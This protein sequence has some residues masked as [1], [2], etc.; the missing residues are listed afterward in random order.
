MI[1]WRLLAL[2]LLAGILGVGTILVLRSSDDG[3][4]SPEEPPPAYDSWRWSD[5]PMPG[6]PPNV[7]LIS[8]D[9]LRADHLGCYGYSRETS[10]NIDSLARQG[11]VFEW[12]ISSSSW[13]LPTHL[14]MLTS[15]HW[16]VWSAE[17]DTN[18]TAVRQPRL[19]GVLRDHGYKTAGFYAGPLVSPTYG[20]DKGFDDYIDCQTTPWNALK[21]ITSPGIHDRVTR[22]LDEERGEP[23][24]LFIHYWDPHGLYIPPAPYDRI[25]DPDYEGKYVYPREPK[26]STADISPRDMKHLIALYD[27]EIRWTDKWIGELVRLLDA[28][29]FLD[30]T[31]IILTADH[32]EQLGE[33]GKIGHGLN[34]FDELIRVPLILRLPGKVPAGVR[35]RE[36]VSLIDIFPTILDVVGVERPPK[37]MGR[38]LA[39]LYQGKP[40]GGNPPPA[41]SSLFEQ[42]FALR[43]AGWKVVRGIDVQGA[44]FYDLVADPLERSPLPATED[45]RGRE[46]L[47]KLQQYIDSL[48]RLRGTLK[49]TG[50]GKVQVDP[51]VLE[52]LRALGYVK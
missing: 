20:F 8:I 38:S 17:T 44:Q 39:P 43:T 25:F 18:W 13:T 6:A 52:R 30:R 29:G 35:V 1:P 33:R 14:S 41:F 16:P 22:W 26:D 2:P 28:K 4:G 49:T 51:E 21:D 32:G 42:A 24:F 47:E 7:V 37:L 48:E 5:A 23:F 36:Q 45:G 15:L 40:E 10:P 27:G 31:L 11:A 50:G 19:P 9:C 34:L 3:S 46:A 12:A